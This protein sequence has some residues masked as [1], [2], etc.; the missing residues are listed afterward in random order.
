MQAHRRPTVQ[1]VPVP[2]LEN[3]MY[4][5][6]VYP[7]Q[8][9]VSFFLMDLMLWSKWASN[10]VPFTTLMALL[11]LPLPPSFTGNCRV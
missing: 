2:E 3:I 8:V 10:A 11:G 5:G 7:G 1:D 9:F 6:T 4:M